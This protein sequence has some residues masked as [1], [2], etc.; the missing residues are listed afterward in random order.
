[1]TIPD[2]W[3]EIKYKYKKLK[4]IPLHW[5]E[6]WGVKMSN[7]AWQKRWCNRQKGTGY[8]RNRLIK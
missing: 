7:Y 8:D 2:L 1:M 4:D 6:H 5:M 3:D